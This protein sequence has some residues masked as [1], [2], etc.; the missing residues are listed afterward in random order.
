M[1]QVLQIRIRNIPHI[2]GTGSGSAKIT[3]TFWIRTTAGT[4]IR[5]QRQHHWC[6][7]WIKLSLWT[8]YRRIRIHIK[9]RK[10]GGIQSV[11]IVWIRNTAVNYQ[12]KNLQTEF[13]TRYLCF[14]FLNCF[15]SVVSP[16]SLLRY[17]KSKLQSRVPRSPFKLSR[18]T[19]EES[20][21]LLI[22]APVT[23]S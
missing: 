19:S 16:W 21:G 14:C 8:L 17:L 18:S 11:K 2:N 23:P 22:P 4:K 7:G 20:L 5:R 12:E 10:L 15:L 3:L 1:D 13:S 6:T 9:L